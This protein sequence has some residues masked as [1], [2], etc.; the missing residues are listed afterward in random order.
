MVLLQGGLALKL[1]SEMGLEA[2][3][4][5]PCPLPQGCVPP[6]AEGKSVSLPALIQCWRS[7]GTFLVPV[8]TS[9]ASTISIQKNH[10]VDEWPKSIHKTNLKWASLVAQQ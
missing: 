9:Y 8:T 3:I 7:P 6:E 5:K 4:Q 2:K 10:P 1:S